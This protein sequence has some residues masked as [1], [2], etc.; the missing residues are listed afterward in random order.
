MLVTHEAGAG[1]PHGF[2][3]LEDLARAI[4]ASATFHGHH[5]D[6]LDYRFNW[7][8]QGRRSYGVG[9]GGIADLAGNVIVP[10]ELDHVR[11]FR[12]RNISLE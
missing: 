2:A 11:Q 8:A 9:F 4:G 12:W 10:G 1:H 5:H 3:I 7:E 6:R